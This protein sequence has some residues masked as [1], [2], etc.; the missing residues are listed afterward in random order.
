MPGGPGAV[1]EPVSGASRVCTRERERDRERER[2]REREGERE[3]LANSL[4]REYK[5]KSV[6]ECTR[7]CVC[8]YLIILTPH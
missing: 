2:K 5:C 6:Q 3:S 8:L 7:V 4:L 1:S